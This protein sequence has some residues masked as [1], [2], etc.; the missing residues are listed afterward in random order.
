MPPAE[1]P[2]RPPVRVLQPAL[3]APAVPA[4]APT[5]PHPSFAVDLP[6]AMEPVLLPKPGPESPLVSPRDFLSPRQSDLLAS[7]RSS[8]SAPNN[9]GT[10]ADGLRLIRQ[11]LEAAIAEIH[12]LAERPIEVSVTTR[13]DGR[14]IAQSVYKDMRERKVKNYETL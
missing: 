9:A 13:L 7:T 1:K 4:L 10:G 5:A 8:D 14:Q 2:A 11:L 3:M 12:S 6:Q